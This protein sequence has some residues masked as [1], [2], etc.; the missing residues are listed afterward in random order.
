MVNDNIPTNYNPVYWGYWQTWLPTDA[1]Q[2][3][4]GIEYTLD[5]VRIKI[6]Y[7]VQYKYLDDTIYFEYIQYF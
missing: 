4:K 3:G 6:I 5:T 1:K 7:R 2:L